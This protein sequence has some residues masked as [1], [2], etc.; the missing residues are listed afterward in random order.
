M[1]IYGAVGI[2]LVCGLIAGCQNGSSEVVT[3]TRLDAALVKTLNNIGVENAILAQ[4]TLYPYHFVAGAECLNELGMR[5]LAVLTR[6]FASYPGVLNVRRDQASDELYEARVTYVVNRLK[7]A[8][9]NVDNMHMADGMPGGSGMS[10]ERV[11]T[12]LQKPGQESM[13]TGLNGRGGV[14]Q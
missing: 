11:V 4:H 6:H 14:L 7:E 10:S 3:N 2:C 12:I 5:D 9:V 13:S 8:G 1:R